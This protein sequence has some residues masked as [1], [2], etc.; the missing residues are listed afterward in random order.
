MIWNCSIYFRGIFLTYLHQNKFF[1]FVPPRYRKEP[2]FIIVHVSI[3]FLVI[4]IDSKLI[5]VLFQEGEVVLDLEF[6]KFQEAFPPAVQHAEKGEELNIEFI[7]QL[8]AKRKKDKGEV[9]TVA[10]KAK[11]VSK[12]FVEAQKIKERT[13]AVVSNEEAVCIENADI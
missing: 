2:Y 13:G 12:D 5:F 6:Y 10:P 9:H 1:E 8:D 7:T 11:A 3:Y 4:Y